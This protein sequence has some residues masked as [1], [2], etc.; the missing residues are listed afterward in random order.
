M[1]IRGRVDVY[2]TIDDQTFV[3][4]A[5]SSEI[6][7]SGRPV[8]VRVVEFQ[9]TEPLYKATQIGDFGDFEFRVTELHDEIVTLIQMQQRWDLVPADAR[10]WPKYYA[11]MPTHMR[12]DLVYA[13]LGPLT[14]IALIDELRRSA[15]TG[16]TS[17]SLVDELLQ[18]LEM[19]D[20]RRPKMLLALATALSAT[21]RRPQHELGFETDFDPRIHLGDEVL[22]ILGSLFLGAIGQ[23]GFDEQTFSNWFRSQ[24]SIFLDDE[25]WPPPG[26]EYTLNRPSH[27][28]PLIWRT[29]RVDFPPFDAQSEK[30]FNLWTVFDG[31]ALQ[32]DDALD[33][34]LPQV[35]RPSIDTRAWARLTTATVQLWHQWLSGE[36][37]QPRTPL[38][39]DEFTVQ[40]LSSISDI[41][42]AT[43]KSLTEARHICF[44]ADLGELL[45]ILRRFPQSVVAEQ[46]IDAL[47]NVCDNSLDLLNIARIAG[48]NLSYEHGRDQFVS[49]V[50]LIASRMN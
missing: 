32:V 4:I 46:A 44:V 24:R 7:E 5:T 37:F 42:S 33:E 28:E 49:D 10:W 8:V 47:Q 48:L 1:S 9:A 6:N 12:G 35:S 26:L 34:E 14:T 38:D 13:A 22:K 17:N 3:A 45:M 2:C 29:E 41:P 39:D 43:W 27:D 21:Q 16:G 11:G 36:G 50:D 18:E 30:K 25:S 19:C 31:L 15:L 40:L 23:F 20:G